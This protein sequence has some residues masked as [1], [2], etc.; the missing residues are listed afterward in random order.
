MKLIYVTSYPDYKVAARKYQSSG[1]I[2]KPISTAKIRDM[3]ESMISSVNDNQK[4]LQV[5]CSRGFIVFDQSGYPVKFSSKKA[6]ELFAY[7]VY[8]NG[9]KCST[10][11]LYRVLFEDEFYNDKKFDVKFF[12]VMRSLMQDL[13]KIGARDVL[14][15]SSRYYALDMTKLDINHGG[16]FYETMKSDTNSYELEFIKQFSWSKNILPD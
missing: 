8:K 15:R 7:L 2:I 3:L 5:E 1:Y 11:E 6:V 12:L 9:A 4:L 13:K 16:L 14:I 10:R